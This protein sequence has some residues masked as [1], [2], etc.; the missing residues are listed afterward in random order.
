MDPV[1]ALG[2]VAA[3]CTTLSFLPQVVHVLRTRDTAAIS[4]WM[5]VVFCTG[6][7]LWLAY[8]VAT[9]DAPVV[10]A[11][12]ITLALAGTVLVLKLRSGFGPRRR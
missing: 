2:W 8:G 5:Y 9:R 1:Q 11:N 12:G 4:G 7:A 6:V 10:A 3:A